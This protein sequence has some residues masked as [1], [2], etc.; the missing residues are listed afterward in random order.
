MTHREKL[1]PLCEKLAQLA[2]EMADQCELTVTVRGMTEPKILVLALLGRTLQNFKGC[3]L[4]TQAKLAVEA[5]VLARCCYENM[6]MVGGLHADGEAF[7]DRMIEDDRAGRKGR[8]RFTFENESIFKGLSDELQTAVAHSKQSLDHAP[9][10]Q[11]LKPKDV[12]GMSAFKE[13][14]I[15]YSQFSGDSAHPTL[16]ALARHWG[17]AERQ[18][19]FFD[20]IPDAKEDELDETLHLAYIAVLGILV[21]VNE[22]HGYIEAGKK[23]PALNDEFITLQAEKYDSRTVADGME[24]R[25]EPSDKI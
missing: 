14:Y 5:R 15:A 3:I 25:T 19:A 11:F 23:L 12:S 8:I 9:R 18:S 2:L 10:F 13:S 6:F 4:L 20:L 24:I 16:T 7:A 17:P 21:V 1:Y 22:M